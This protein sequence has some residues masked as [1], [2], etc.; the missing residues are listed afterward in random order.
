[1]VGRKKRSAT[2]IITNEARVLRDLRIR[3]GLSMR[4]A[5]DLIK[6]SD[7]YIA[8][9]ET[10]RM[11]P[12]T[13]DRLEKLLAIYGGI[14]Q[15]TFYEKVRKY[16]RR[17]PDRDHLSEVVRRLPAEKVTTL[18]IF[19]QVL[20]AGEMPDTVA[21]LLT[22]VFGAASLERR[23]EMAKKGFSPVKDLGRGR[24]SNSIT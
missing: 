3:S 2:I 21:D 8:H 17:I 20:V 11:D 24:T 15:K 22:S 23:G 13:G 9:I 14:K 6:L 12:P 4:K 7:T 18:L 10:G 19:A 16:K 1:M 5:A